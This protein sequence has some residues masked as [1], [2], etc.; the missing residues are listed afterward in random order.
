MDK[1]AVLSDFTK[2]ERRIL[3]VLSD[4]ENHFKEEL[5]ASLVDDMADLSA[6]MMHI[7]RLRKKLRL[8]GEDIKCIVCDYGLCYCHV[9]LLEV[10]KLDS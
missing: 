6:L 5:L 2:N 9:G 7:S 8:V 4:G 1:S 3:H 10:Q